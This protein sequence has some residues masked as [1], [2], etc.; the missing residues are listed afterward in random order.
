MSARFWTNLHQV[1]DISARFWT[2]LHQ[3]NDISAPFWTNLHQVNDISANIIYLMKVSPE[4][5]GNII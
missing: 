4:T 5:G 1:N 2:N 3:V